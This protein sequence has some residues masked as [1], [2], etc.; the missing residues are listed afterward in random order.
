MVGTSPE[1][2]PEIRIQVDFQK[3]RF[4]PYVG[5]DLMQLKV[6]S[7]RQAI[8]FPSDTCSGQAAVLCER[9][10]INLMIFTFVK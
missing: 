8:Q 5:N 6:D 1:I 9:C 7:V 10:N 3:F 2:Y 4:G